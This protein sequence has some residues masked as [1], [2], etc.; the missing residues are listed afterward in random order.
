MS[1]KYQPPTDHDHQPLLVINHHEASVWTCTNAH[2]AYIA[3][4]EPA[5]QADL[6]TSC[7]AKSD[8]LWTEGDLRRWFMKLISLTLASVS[9]F[10]PILMNMAE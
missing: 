2:A 9:E 8:I 7:D 5:F 6:A 10:W 4:D 3:M 1:Y